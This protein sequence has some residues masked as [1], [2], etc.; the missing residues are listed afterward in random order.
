MPLPGPSSCVR[1]GRESLDLSKAVYVG[2]LV[3][4]LPVSLAVG[5][6]AP[7]AGASVKSENAFNVSSTLFSV[8]AAI[9]A[10]GY[11]A[12]IDSSLN[13]KYKLRLQVRDELKKRQIPS[14][15]ELQAFYK[16][17]KKPTAT[18]DLSQY[19]SFAMITT[20]PPNFEVP[21]QSPPEVQALS[22]FRELLA[23]FYKEAN[24][25]D[26]WNRSQTAYIA[27]ISEY[28]DPVIGTLFKAN[29]YLRNP[30]S[31]LGRRFEVFLDLLAAPE[32]IQVRSYRDNFFVIISP[33]A[34]P[35]VDEVRDAYL[36]YVLD[37]LTFKYSDLI[38]SKKALQKYA[39]EAPALDLAYKDDW[40]LLVTKCLT[41]AIDSR[42]IRG[43]EK[44]QA[45]INQAMSEGFI[46]SAALADALPAYE[47]QQDAFRLYYP[48]LISSVDV[49]K[50]EKRLRTVQFAQSVA[51]R[52][53]AA[54][55]KL[56]IEPAEESLQNAEGLYEQRDLESARKLYRKVLEQTADPAKQGR[57]YY[58]LGLIDLQ[59]KRWDEALNL[60]GKTV[61]ANPSPSLTAWAHYYL[62]QLAVKA[63]DSDKAAAEFKATLAIGG[64]SAR[65]REAAE[66]AM[67]SNSGEIKQ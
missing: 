51:P 50:E 28:Q 8:L 58:G 9:N 33:S 35:V 61:A 34:A 65:A 11:E 32:Q 13:E 62:G 56:Q 38:K 1:L 29:G 42:L 36:A 54:P 43:P 15:P 14:L 48:N 17:H 6:T 45:F 30:S 2:I 23:R 20:G 25:E 44:R 12:G 40:S 16:A 53:V 55:A 19:I 24:L 41:K 64:A 21:E 46:L 59:E 4:F 49:R 66:K 52:P 47:K 7:F 39:E 37:P 60:F 18:A 63:G 26:L 67:Q 31:Y 10:A 5:Q 27:A 3:C 57:A 22:G